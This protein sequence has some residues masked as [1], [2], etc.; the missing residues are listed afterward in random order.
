MLRSSSILHV[1]VL[2]VCLSLVCDLS[3][4]SLAVL[5]WQV[6]SLDNLV[7][8]HDHRFMDWFEGSDMVI[9]HIS[10]SGEYMVINRTIVLIIGND[11]VVE[12]F[13][14]GPIST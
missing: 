3:T 14:K 5:R 7:E 6:L 10:R 12:S 11:G 2:Q 4:L 8:E 9:T 13:H 1:A